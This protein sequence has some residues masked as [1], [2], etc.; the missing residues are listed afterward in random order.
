MTFRYVLTGRVISVEEKR[1]KLAAVQDSDGKWSVPE[2]GI[3]WFVR[4]A[5]SSSIFVGIEKPDIAVGDMIRMT[6]EKI[7]VNR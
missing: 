5:Q 4:I 2:M 3:G 1:V 7:N 6:M